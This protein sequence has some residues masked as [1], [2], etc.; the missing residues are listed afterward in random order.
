MGKNLNEKIDISQMYSKKLITGKVT[1]TAGIRNFQNLN[2]TE[3]AS[4]NRIDIL[5]ALEA[6]TKF[7]LIWYVIFITLGITCLFIEPKSWFYVLDLFVLMVNV[8]L[9]T[10]GKVSGIY[11]GIVDCLMYAYVSFSSGLYGEAIKMLLIN[12]PLNIFSI[13]SWTRSYRKQKLD[14]KKYKNQENSL[15]IRRINLKNIWWLAIIFACL[16][17]VSY[18]G[19]NNIY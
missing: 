18:F 5:K 15:V 9:V 11:V 2:L 19:F 3:Y 16:Y 17:T 10:R 12:I 1:A 7:R 8:D 4:K 14:N 6:S 13:I